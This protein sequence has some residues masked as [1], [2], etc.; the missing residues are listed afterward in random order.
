MRVTLNSTLSVWPSNFNP[1]TESAKVSSNSGRSMYRIVPA[2]VCFCPDFSFV[3]FFSP[4][5]RYLAFG[6]W[7]VT[8]RNKVHVERHFNTQ[9]QDRSGD[10]LTL[11][12]NVVN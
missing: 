8:I 11:S 10:I 5:A 4:M 1:A 6:F 9:S 3:G 2:G 12:L 7:L